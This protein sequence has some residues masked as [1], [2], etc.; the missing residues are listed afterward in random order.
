MVSAQWKQLT[1][2]VPSVFLLD[3]LVK[4]KKICSPPRFQKHEDRFLS[5]LEAEPLR[6]R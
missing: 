6:E 5:T 1:G 4:L 2:M 3:F